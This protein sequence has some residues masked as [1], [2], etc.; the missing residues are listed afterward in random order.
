MKVNRIPRDRKETS[1]DTS[2]VF[3]L[4]AIGGFFLAFFGLLGLTLFSGCYWLKDA[5]VFQAL[6]ITLRA[7]LSMLAFFGF[8]FF[9]GVFLF[10]GSCRPGRPILAKTLLWLSFL[11][12][13]FSFAIQFYYLFSWGFFWFGKAFFGNQPFANSKW[14]EYLGLLIFT[15]TL[16]GALV[17]GSS[18]F[19]RPSRT[20]RRT[21]K[22]TA[23]SED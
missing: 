1:R 7:P 17:T 14:F 13:L 18:V 6:G 21:P 10:I 4:P 19:Q 11:F 16:T 12:S 2:D 20:R 22:E 3:L 23:F 15:I 9:A 5:Q 8:S